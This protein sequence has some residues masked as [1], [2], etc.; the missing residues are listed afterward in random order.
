MT[1]QLSVISVELVDGT[2]V[3]VPDSLELITPYVL[4]EQGDWFEDEIKF[5]RRLVQPGDTVVDIGANYGVY[6]LSLARKVGPSGQVW[7][8]EPATDTAQ[9][10]RES[11]NAN[12]TTWLHVVQQALSDHEGTAWLE[13]PGQ[14]ELNRLAK[15]EH[16]G[17]DEQAIPG[18]TV[19]ITTLDQCLDRFNWKPIDL[20][21][22]DAEGAEESILNGGIRFFKELSPLVMFEVKAGIDLNL[23]LIKSFKDLGYQSFRLVPGLDTL[24]QFS[25]NQNADEYLLNL[26]AAKPDRIAQLVT[27][28]LLVEQDKSCVHEDEKLPNDSWLIALQNQ[29]YAKSIASDWQIATPLEEQRI[30]HRAL[31][32]WTIA[33]KGSMPI[34][35]R[36]AALSCSYELLKNAIK[37]DCPLGRLASLTRVAMA[38]G[39]RAQAVNALN[40]LI[41]NL[42]AGLKVDRNEP[43]LCPGPAFDSVP[44][45]VSLED[46]LEAAGLTTLEYL[47]S[48]SSFY[49]VNE[50]KMRL[51]R[52]SSLGYTE[53]TMQHRKLLISR[54]LRDSGSEPK[55]TPLSEE[56]ALEALRLGQR[57]TALRIYFELLQITDNNKG[58]IHFQISMIYGLLSET[59]NQDRHIILAQ[60]INP[61]DPNVTLSFGAYLFRGG[62]IK[63]A[64]KHFIEASQYSEVRSLAFSN[65]AAVESKEGNRTEALSYL[66]KSLESEPDNSHALDLALSLN[67]DSLNDRQS[68]DSFILQFNQSNTALIFTITGKHLRKR[69]LSELAIEY[70]ERAIRVDHANVSAQLERASIL[71][72]QG[73]SDEAIEQLLYSLT[74][75]PENIDVLLG[76]G[77]CSQQIGQ[78]DSAMYFYRKIL[79]IEKI[80]P[81]VSN[82]LGCAIRL[83]GCDQEAI[84]IFVEA[85]RH[86]PN[87]SQIMANL[88]S[89]LRN[90]GRTAESLEF[91]KKILSINP[92][93]EEGF[94]S[95]MFTLSTLPKDHAR[96]IPTIAHDFWSAFR[97]R[98]ILEDHNWH[99]IA[100]SSIKQTANNELHFSQAQTKLKIA[101]LSAEIGDHVVGMFMRS[102]LANYNHSLFHVTLITSLRRFEQIEQD[103]INLADNAINLQGLSRLEAAKA[104]KEQELDI[105]I[106]TSGYTNNSQIGLLAFR[107][108]RIQC[109]YIG[110]HAST[111]LDSIDYFIGDSIVTPAEF[112]ELFSESIIRLTSPWIALSHHESPPYAS[113]AAQVTSFTFGSFNQCSKFN[114]KTFSYWASA[115][116]AVPDS[117]LVIKDRSLTSESR[118]SWISN[119]LHELGIAI[120]RICFVGGVKSWTEHMDVY[121][122]VD[123]CLDC[124]YWSGSTTVFDSLSMGTPY[125]AIKG[126]TMSSRMSSSILSG[127]G[128]DN[129]IAN[130]QLEFGA[131][132]KMLAKDFS[133]TRH[134]KQ[135]RQAQVLHELNVKSVQTTRQLEEALLTISQSKI[136]Q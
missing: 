77:Y 63:E 43:F 10:L 128:Y 124:T 53:E 86:H 27:R 129:W 57:R 125:I 87:D 99:H 28:G 46:W 54:R 93:S 44:P 22:I 108:A 24:V 1:N 20:L 16:E 110:Y 114:Q 80:H 62:Q 32:A 73:R 98:L 120:S 2:N 21:K 35:Q 132:A 90:V 8:F 94:Y 116:H 91:S 112:E 49:S 47:S 83:T 95:T 126:E 59:E 100:N 89:T 7:A 70:I 17:S 134:G 64:R 72:S 60:R 23:G 9:L 30:I 96:Q 37:T 105:I 69:G 79:A 50:S 34:T 40:K 133:D 92:S 42:Q 102:F 121:N 104:I 26:F 39:E 11:S 103:L 31:Q 36:Y 123:A 115:L 52:L 130:N 122:I 14:A 74:I 5:L 61:V 19:E 119:S 109:H 76:M 4:Q 117:F 107:L 135:R 41:T 48:F 101:F 55:S 15:V 18:E 84:P 127:Y 75:E 136:N 65:L 106:D 6:A 33:Q 45:T 81:R 131:I 111:G 56:S 118:R 82:L 67:A 51:K 25:E 85:L 68:I 29:P 58:L 113:S 66:N 38:L 78:L 3:M 71:S 13:M 12:D 88:A 97:E